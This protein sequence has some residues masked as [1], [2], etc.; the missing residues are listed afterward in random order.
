MK[1]YRKQFPIIIF[2]F[3]S[4]LSSRGPVRLIL[5]ETNSHRQSEILLGKVTTSLFLLLI[6]F[7]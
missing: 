1:M 4:G 2:R 5:Y 3:F 7:N 6:I